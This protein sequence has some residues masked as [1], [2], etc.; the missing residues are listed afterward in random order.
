M[1][2]TLKAVACETVNALYARIVYTGLC[3]QL[4]EGLVEQWAS[5]LVLSVCL[6]YLVLRSYMERV[7]GVTGSTYQ[8]PIARPMSNQAGAVA[9]ATA[10]AAVVDNSGSQIKQQEMTHI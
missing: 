3:T 9:G 6:S 10:P 1:D 7:Q 8:L 2:D 5:G 4:I